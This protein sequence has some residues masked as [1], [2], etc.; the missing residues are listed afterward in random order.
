MTLVKICGIRTLQE[1]E[2]AW[3]AGSWA[4]GQIFCPSR[5]RIGVEEAAQLNRILGQR[6]V[7]IGVFQNQSVP[8]IRAVIRECGLDMAQL[9]GDESPEEAAAL[10]VPVIKAFALTGPVNPSLIDPWKVWGVLF[11]SRA[12]GQVGGSGITFPW[13][14]LAPLQGRFN[15]LIAGGL[16]A[17][18]VREAMRRV[19]PLAVDVSSGVEYRGGGKDPSQIRAFIKQVEE[20]NRYGS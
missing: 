5:R 15:L 7:K 9:H 8:E 2:A 17:G 4:I 16:N 19:R 3:Q 6:V 11:D 20:E 1:A 13:A 14:W 12:E 18:N 10:P